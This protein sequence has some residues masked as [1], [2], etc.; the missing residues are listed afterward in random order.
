MKKRYVIGIIISLIFLYFAFKEVKF[1]E[2]IGALEKANYLILIP[3][4]ATV[5]AIFLVRAYRWNFLILPVKKLSYGKLFSALMI[6]TMANNVLPFRIGEIVRAFIIG[7]MGNVSRSASFATIAVERVIDIFTI[8]LIATTVIS[9][10]EMPDSM[11]PFQQIGLILLVIVVVF[12]G[13]TL[14]LLKNTNFALNVLGK[15][16]KPLPEKYKEKIIQISESFIT[17]L[18]VIKKK[19]YYLVIGLL[20]L[21]AWFLFVLEAYILFFAFDL[22]GKYNVPIGAS[23]LIVILGTIAIMIPSSPGFFGTFHLFCKEGL[24]VYNVPEST[25]LAY[26]VILHAFSFLPTTILGIIYLGKKNFTFSQIKMDKM[27]N[28]TGQNIS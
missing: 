19:E 3:V 12:F 21:A 28:D 11:F 27:N 25:A 14:F 22:P 2:F 17:G 9:L 26:A 8:L 13:F 4:L 1:K 20:S 7:K 10:Q 5:I 24:T 16:L 18:K 6:G 23:F 15:L